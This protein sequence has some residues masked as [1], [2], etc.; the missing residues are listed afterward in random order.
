MLGF[1]LMANIQF[2]M[3]GPVGVEQGGKVIYLSPRMVTL[4][5]AL[6]ASPNSAVP[7][8]ALI[9]WLW[10]SRPPGDPR[11]V[12]RDLVSGFRRL[13]GPGVVEAEPSGYKVVADAGSLDSLRFAHLRETA[14]RL[15]AGGRLADAAANL[16]QAVALWREPFLGNVR[17]TA[18][19]AELAP[20]FT[21][22]YLEAVEARAALYLRLDRPDVVIRDLPEVIRAYPYRE[23]TAGM[24]MV[25]LANRGDRA[26]ALDAYDALSLR[27]RDGLGMAPGDEVRE[28]RAEIASRGRVSSRH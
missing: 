14:D 12:L 25:A 23:R 10:E 5:A 17:S 21:W 13:F 7:D 1:R 24:F 26:A 28:V 9:G 18:L 11:A 15:A 6:L 27:L 20:E 22:R 2:R 19:R 16:D 3:L 4:L 8:A